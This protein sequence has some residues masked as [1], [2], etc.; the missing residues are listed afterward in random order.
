VKLALVALTACA[1]VAP[2]AIEHHAVIP[3]RETWIV[4]APL[5]KTND[6]SSVMWLLERNGRAARLLVGA[7]EFRGTVEYFGDQMDF[8]LGNA[9]LICKRT[10]VR[11]HVAGAEPQPRGEHP[12]CS[13]PRVWQPADLVATP[14]LACEVQRY[15]LVTEVTMAASPGLQAVVDDCCDDE[16]RCERRW[17]IRRRP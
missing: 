16:D 12:I 17:E 3:S 8:N 2:P 9:V 7:Q 10:T 5:F 11:V 4:D 15:E 14:A 13:T 1:T 6:V